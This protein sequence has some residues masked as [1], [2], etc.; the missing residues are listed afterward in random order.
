ML[1]S[2][3]ER[4]VFLYD[5]GQLTAGVLYVFQHG[6]RECHIVVL[7]EEDIVEWDDDYPPQMGEEYSQSKCLSLI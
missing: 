2:C 6:D 1:N 3:E 5:W 4:Q 7:T